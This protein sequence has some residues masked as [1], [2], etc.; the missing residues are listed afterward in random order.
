MAEALPFE[1]L[2]HIN[3]KYVMTVSGYF[4][5]ISVESVPE[6]VKLV[7]LLFYYNC[8]DSS[9]L[10]LDENDKLLELFASQNK[11]KD[12]GNYEYKLIYKASRDG[13]KGIIFQAL[14]HGEQNIL[15]IISTGDNVFGGYTSVGWP[16][17]NDG[18]QIKDNKAFI[19][20]IRSSKDWPPAIFNII[21]DK[22]ALSIQ[23]G[24]HCVF[25]NHFC[26]FLNNF[27]QG[28][29]L[30]PTSYEPAK[31]YDYLFGGR[32]TNL[33]DVDIEDVEVFQLKASD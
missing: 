24:H 16:I 33:G 17:H 31:H 19:F 5:K 3:D 15:C 11:F 30:S 29:G 10:R 8:I 23:H 4:R 20:S 28:G 22:V 1:R 27:G 6:S 26:I 32:E 13:Q 18:K 14:V 21:Q 2:K 12:L 9:I 7:V 25:G